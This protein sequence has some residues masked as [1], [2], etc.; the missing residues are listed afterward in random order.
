MLFELVAKPDYLSMSEP[1]SMLIYKGIGIGF[2]Q[3]SEFF[4]KIAVKDYEL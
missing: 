4:G 3:Q 1:T 2:E